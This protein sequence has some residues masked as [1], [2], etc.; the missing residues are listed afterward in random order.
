MASCS[1]GRSAGARSALSKSSRSSS[2]ERARGASP[3]MNCQAK[4][5]LRHDGTL[6]DRQPSRACRG[7]LTL[8]EACAYAC[9]RFADRP[10]I[11]YCNRPVCT[12]PAP[13]RARPAIPRTFRPSSRAALLIEEVLQQLTS[14][15]RLALGAASWSGRRPLVGHSPNGDGTAV[16]CHAAGCHALSGRLQQHHAGA[17]TAFPPPYV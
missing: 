3:A 6:G 14:L 5:G 15:F 7:G 10:P 11:Q 17:T 1:S 9:V 13:L 8:A 12:Q 16:R 4:R 2:V